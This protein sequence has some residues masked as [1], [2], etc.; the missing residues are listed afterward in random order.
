MLTLADA[1]LLV[2][3]GR[4]KRIIVQGLA[5]AAVNLYH[6]LMRVG[7]YNSDIAQVIVDYYLA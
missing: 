4:R 3:R 2:V 6:E 1:M 5:R 7:D